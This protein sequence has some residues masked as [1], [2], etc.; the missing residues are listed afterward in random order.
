M[1]DRSEHNLTEI[2]DRA[3]QTLYAQEVAIL[4]E[5]GLPTKPWADLDMKQRADVKNAYLPTVMAVLDA[6]DEV[7]VGRP[8]LEQFTAIV[9]AV[10]EQVDEDLSMIDDT[11]VTTDALIRAVRAVDPTLIDTTTRESS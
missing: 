1:T 10:Q 3:V 9:V 8:T 7:E 6:A 4:T 11:N 2:V 5:G